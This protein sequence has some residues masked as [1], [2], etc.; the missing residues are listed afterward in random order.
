MNSVSLQEIRPYDVMVP[1]DMLR[2]L[3]ETIEKHEAIGALAG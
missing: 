3:I 2:P 1:G